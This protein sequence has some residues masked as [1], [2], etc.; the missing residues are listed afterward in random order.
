MLMQN[1]GGATKSIMV[2]LKRPICIVTALFLDL[3]Q[4]SKGAAFINGL[5]TILSSSH[6]TLYVRLAVVSLFSYATSC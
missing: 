1:F 6:E 2:S 5:V 4:K 3:L